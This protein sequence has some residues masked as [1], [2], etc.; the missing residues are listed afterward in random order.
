MIQGVAGPAGV[1]GGIDSWSGLTGTITN[2]QIETTLDNLGYGGT[3]EVFKAT[4]LTTGLEDSVQLPEAYNTYRTLRVVQFADSE[5]R[6][7]EIPIYLLTDTNIANDTTIRIQGAS[8]I[9]F[10][11][12]NRT[13]SVPGGGT[14][15]YQLV[16]EN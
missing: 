11:S 7:Q 14:I 12:S 8:D 13:V 3:L 6:I 1:D 16:L 9:N 10:N 15:I 2:A 5:V 4:N